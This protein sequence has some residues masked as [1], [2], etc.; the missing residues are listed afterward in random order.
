MKTNSQI[1][2]I[3]R[4]L[5]YCIKRLAACEITQAALLLKLKQRGCPAEIAQKAIDRMLEKGYLNDK[6][7]GER[8]VRMWRRNG[9]SGLG[10]LKITMHTQGIDGAL[11]QELLAAITD[12]EELEYA[13]NA[14]S[15]YHL[16]S[17]DPKW[18]DKAL[19]YL[20]RRG[21]ALTTARKIVPESLSA[22]PF[23]LS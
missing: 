15:T 20:V 16:K 3:E 14:F 10:K 5:E 9:K 17:D 8:L 7:S 22:P 19:A 2:T 18:K 12:D 11:Q 23:D 13:R 1:V 6:R 21:F 4:A